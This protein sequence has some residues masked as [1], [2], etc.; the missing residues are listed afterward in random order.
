M[1]NTVSLPVFHELIKDIDRIS[2][3]ILSVLK[4]SFLTSIY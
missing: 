1:S 4:K 3:N 2:K